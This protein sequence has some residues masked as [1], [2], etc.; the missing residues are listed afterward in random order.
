MELD[1]FGKQPLDVY[2]KGDLIATTSVILPMDRLGVFYWDVEDT[3]ANSDKYVVKHTLQDTG[4]YS[5]DFAHFKI[6]STEY[7]SEINFFVA[8]K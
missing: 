7:R 4:G 3:I 8:K 5:I 6:N 2:F 1:F